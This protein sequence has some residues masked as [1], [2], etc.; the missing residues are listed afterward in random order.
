LLACVALEFAHPRDGRGLR[1][2]ATPGDEFELVV[3]R[4]GWRMPAGPPDQAL[5]PPSFSLSP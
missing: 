5:T 1:F 4:L 3:Q 2:E